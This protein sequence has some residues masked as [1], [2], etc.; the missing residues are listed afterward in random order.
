MV[1]VFAVN[2]AMG[3]FLGRGGT[4]FGNGAGEQQRNS[5]QW[6]IAIDHHL[7]ISDVGN[8][9]QTI[10]ALAIL[11]AALELHAD[12]NV[13]RKQ[14]A[15]FNRDQVGVIFAKCIL[16]L[17]SYFKD[18]ALGLALKFFFDTI[19]DAA[20]ASVQIDQRSRTFID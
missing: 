9:E 6:V 11:G 19:E 18:I 16:G 10:L 12:F 3:Y 5:R 14:L 4:N 20:V 13:F 2:V 17:Q 8:G 15:R 7:V 1:A